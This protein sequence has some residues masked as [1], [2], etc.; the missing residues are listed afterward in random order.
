MTDSA[1]HRPTYRD[2]S[3][4]GRDYNQW[5]GRFEASDRDEQADERADED[6]DSG[7]NW[8]PP[9]D[10]NLIPDPGFGEEDEFCR[11]LRAEMYAIVT[12][13]DTECIPQAQAVLRLLDS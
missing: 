13:N 3:G 4:F 1:A 2:E 10:P 6:E 11:R 5:T 7:Y 12:G 8:G 9:P